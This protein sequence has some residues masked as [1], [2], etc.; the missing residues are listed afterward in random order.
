MQDEGEEEEEIAINVVRLDT[1]QEIVLM[2]TVKNQ[3]E[4]AI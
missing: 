3:V 2:K 1:L 4:L